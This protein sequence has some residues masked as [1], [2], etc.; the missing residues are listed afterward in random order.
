M[1]MKLQP[2]SNTVTVSNA[3]RTKLA[4]PPSRLQAGSSD[5]VYHLYLRELGQI[6]FLTA[7]EEN[8]LARSA[9]QGDEL[10]REK[11][12]KSHLRLVVKVARDYEGF[13]VPL[14]DLISEGNIGLMKAADKY[15]ADRGARFASYAIW[16]VR[17]SVRRALATQLRT[18]R[19][20]SHAEEKLIRLSRVA[21][22]FRE[23]FG[24]EATDGELAEEMGLP[25]V[26]VRR[27]RAAALRPVSL[28]DTTG[29]GETRELAESLAD[30]RC[31]CPAQALEEGNTAEYVRALL[32]H[33]PPRERTVLTQRF[34]LDG[35]EECT[36]QQIG[37]QF[38]VTR[39]CVRVI[40]N[41]AL[42]RLRKKVK[43]LAQCA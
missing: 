7:E 15:D 13:G 11:L 2:R 37:D 14:L 18:I 5:P 1:T 20:P 33:L 27:L 16:W 26:K 23:E 24:R 10:A 38:G 29:D 9:Q 42:A 21:L 3:P 17:Q 4:A 32:E 43:P 35:D 25:E 8:A 30:E 28:Q 6:P 34:G 41:R 39:E 31:C 22:R 36:F 19:L 12:I 40:Q